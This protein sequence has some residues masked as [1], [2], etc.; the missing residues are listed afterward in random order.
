[1]QSGGYAT[2]VAVT[3]AEKIKHYPELAAPKLAAA[4]A[5]PCSVSDAVE[6]LIAA[7]MLTTRGVSVL[8]F[9]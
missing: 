9:K 2:W 8:C 7:R 5:T 3:W 4:L 6:C 1:M